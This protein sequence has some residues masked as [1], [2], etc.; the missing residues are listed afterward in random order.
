M[1]SQY[2]YPIICSE[3][4]EQ[5]VAFYEDHLGFTPD[6]EMKNFV[7]LKRDDYDGMYI[8]VIDSNHEA[9][10]AE[11]KRPVQGMLLNYP[12]ESVVK[13]YDYAYHEGLKLLSEPK[14]MA[15]G[16]KH[17][18]IEDPNGILID[19]AE[20]IDIR[21]MLTPE[22]CKNIVYMQQA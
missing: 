4:F 22:N 17:F 2:S 13:F 15:C 19:I 21:Q 3:K 1:L 8:A 11:Y 10:P 20:N 18:Y 7:I 5:T 9:L 6:F 14:D 12:V 16:R